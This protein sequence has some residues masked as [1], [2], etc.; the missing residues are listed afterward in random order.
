LKC[1]GTKS[2][3]TGCA[4]DGAKDGSGRICRDWIS[5]Q[6][7]LRRDLIAFATESLLGIPVDLFELRSLDE[8]GKMPA[9]SIYPCREI[10]EDSMLFQVPPETQY[11][12]RFSIFGIPTRIHPGFWIIA[13]LLGWRNAEMGLTSLN[14]LGIFVSILVHELGHAL[15]ARRY[16]WP[17]IIVLY[18]FGGLAVYQPTFGHTRK[19]SAWISFAGPLAG[20]VLG[21]LAYGLKYGWVLCIEANQSWAVTLWNS[22]FGNVLDR[23]SYFFIAINM[24]WGLFNLLPV[25]PLDGGS[26]CYEICNA[27]QLRS[28]QIRTH[29]IGAFTAVLAGAWFLTNGNFFGGLMF[30]GLAYENYRK[31]ERLRH[32]I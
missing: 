9:L 18:T 32:N 11:D 31:Q 3:N 23:A 7:E 19:R 12:L 17:P 29:R 8:Y 26:I 15:A 30:A 27:R 20:F 5:G 21:G 4:V 10:T 2:I 6:D 16:G 22:D 24:V 28:G 13:L 25:H 14:V 1:L